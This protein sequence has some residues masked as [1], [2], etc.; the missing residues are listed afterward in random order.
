MQHP[1]FLASVPDNVL[2]V[3]VVDLSTPRC[4]CVDDIAAVGRIVAIV[5]HRYNRI[6]AE[7]GRYRV[8]DELPQRVG[9][10]GQIRC[11]M[12]VVGTPALNRAIVTVV[13]VSHRVYVFEEG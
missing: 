2:A 10:S 3:Q 12:T 5:E 4:D 13:S 8:L 11:G 7:R 9:A 1:N 6:S